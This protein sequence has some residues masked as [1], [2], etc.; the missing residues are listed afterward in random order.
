LFG[1]KL[2]DPGN[3]QLLGLICGPSGM[4]FNAP[5]MGGPMTTITGQ[6]QPTTLATFVAGKSIDVYF[7]AD[8]FFHIH[9]NIHT[10]TRT[11]NFN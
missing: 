9:T 10:H 4:N 5:L 11:V 7:Y 1:F 6:P 3:C 8:F 2:I